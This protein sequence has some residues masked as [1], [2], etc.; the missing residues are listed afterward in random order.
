MEAGKKAP[1]KECHAFLW[2]LLRNS[3]FVG[4]GGDKVSFQLLVHIHEWHVVR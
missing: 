2:A 1:L 3:K 4:K